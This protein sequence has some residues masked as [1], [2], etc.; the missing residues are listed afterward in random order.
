MFPRSINFHLLRPCNARCRYCFARFPETPTR[1]SGTEAIAVMR[2]VREAGGEKINFVGGEPTLHPEIERLIVAAKELGF[3]TSIVSNGARLTQLLSSPGGALLDWVGLSVDSTTDEGN[4]LVG[5]GRPGYVAQVLAHA[6]QARANG[7]AVKLNT[8][9]T[10]LNATEDLSDLVLRIAPERWK[11]FQVLRVRGQNEDTISD[12]MVDAAAFRAF[13]ARHAGL[14][15]ADIPVIAEDN[16]SMTDSYAMIDPLGRFFGNTGGIHRIGPPILEVGARESLASVGFD[17]EK[18]VERGG[19]YEWSASAQH[20]RLPVADGDTTKPL[21][22][23]IEGLDGTGKSTTVKLLAKELAAAVVNNPPD[24]LIA[25]RARADRLAPD[26]RRAW[27]LEA[28]RIAMEEARSHAANGPAVVLDR[29]VA[30]TLAFRAAERGEV[31][32]LSDVPS[33]QLLPDVIVFLQLS[34]R[35]RLRRHQ[36]RSEPKTGEERRLAGD[37]AFRRRVLVGYQRLCTH[38]VSAAPEPAR[39]VGEILKVLARAR[40]ER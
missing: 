39:V 14:A 25:D 10:R 29:S 30:S 24:G 12:L 17:S 36:G 22:V 13:V 26:K 2:H 9:V 35:E 3:T 6:E 8:V 16:D 7:A 5:R 1:L 28:N 37:R 18:L 31:A 40:G 38:V 15:D 19:E 4:A 11:V 20:R 32:S 21:V 34:E 27:Y 33:R 23:A